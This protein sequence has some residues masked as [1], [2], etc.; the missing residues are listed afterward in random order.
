MKQENPFWNFLF[1]IIIPIAILNNSDK[2]GDN[3]PLIALVLALAFPIGYSVR[4]I[5]VSGKP[6]MIAILGLL[7]VVFT[8]GLA[9]LEVEGIWFAVKEAAFP[10]VIGVAVSS[11]GLY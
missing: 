5:I 6:N 10:A 1:N 9:L 2:F 3:G 11:F 8:G 7:N 4:D